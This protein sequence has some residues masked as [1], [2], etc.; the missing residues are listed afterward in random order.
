VVRYDSLICDNL[1]IGCKIGAYMKKTS[2]EAKKLFYLGFIYFFSGLPFG[3]FYTF[4]PVFL[5]T[6]GVSLVNIGLFSLASLPWSLRLVWAPFID[7]YLH[8][9][10]WM[11]FSLVGIGVSVL[12]LSLVSPQ[13]ELFFSCLFLL[14]FFSSVFDTAAD[15]FVVEWIAQEALGKANGLRIAA[16]RV[17]LIVFGG[18]LVA[19]SHYLGFKPIFYLIFM[20]GLSVG[21]FLSLNPFLK[22]K[23]SQKPHSLK[24]QFILPVK[25]ILKRKGAFYLFLFVFSYKIGD[26]LLGAMVYPF[27]VDRGFSRLEIGMIAGTIGS[28]LTI[29]GS[30]LGGY[31]SSQW[32]VKKSLLILGF[33]QAFSNLGYT[34][35]SIP[36]LPKQ[37]VYLASIIESFT[38]GLGTAA[39]LTFLTKLCQKEFSA[40][41]YAV[42][43]TLFSLSLTFS[44]SLSGFLTTYLGYTFFFGLT[45]LISLPAFLLI[46]KITKDLNSKPF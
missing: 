2:T 46:P 45:F 22:H 40:T 21:S 11:G 7:R 24:E 6:E 39:F 43:S 34:L 36:T 4:I 25:E 15:G 14:C 8:K 10:L 5:R 12:F 44:R 29:L 1:K 23:I 35:A 41:Q 42:F 19:I 16:Y 18:G 20:I 33:F 32:T 13:D 28:L 30:L 37:T 26:S 31:L 38:G 3:F 9:S 17:S 27:W